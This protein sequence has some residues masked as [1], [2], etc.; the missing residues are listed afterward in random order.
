MSNEVMRREVMEAIAAGERALYSLRKAQEKLNSAKNW[1]LFDMF[2]GGFFSSMIKHSNINESA[3]Y[4]EA[5]KRDLQIFQKELR[6]V[7]VRADFH[8]E[9]GNFLTFA[10]FFFD[11]IVA[12]YMVQSKIA[13]AR[14]QVDDAIGRVR[15]MLIELKQLNGMEDE[16]WDV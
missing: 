9:V 12:D 14:M 15:H 10:D 7:S 8:I 4:M 2:G 16:T 1:G 13:D 3:Q 6:D 5:A 11:G